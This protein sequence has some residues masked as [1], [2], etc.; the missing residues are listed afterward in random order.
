MITAV[1]DSENLSDQETAM[2]KRKRRPTRPGVILKEHYLS[3]RSIS[4]S[5]FADAVGYSRKQISAIVNG[6]APIEPSLAA[7]MAKVLGTTADFWLN[8]Q[9]AVDAF[10][11]EQET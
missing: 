6:N 4:I 1:A 8:L 7:R 9:T 3:P 5:G 10:D 11:A 2:L